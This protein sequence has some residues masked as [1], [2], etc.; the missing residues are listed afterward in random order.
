MPD[1]DIT[2]TEYLRLSDDGCPN[3]PE[4]IDYTDLYRWQRVFERMREKMILDV[5]AGGTL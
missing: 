5:L 1:S 2:M 3:C 4:H